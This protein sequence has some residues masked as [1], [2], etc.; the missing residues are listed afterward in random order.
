MSL[1]VLILDPAFSADG[2]EG[3]MTQKQ[4]DKHIADKAAVK[5][6]A[7]IPAGWTGAFKSGSSWAALKQQPTRYGDNKNVPG[8]DK[9]RK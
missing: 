3:K 9:I 1:H 6:E 4:K 8:R 2:Y 7:S 5:K